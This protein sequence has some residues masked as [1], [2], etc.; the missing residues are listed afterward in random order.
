MP[1]AGGASVASAELSVAGGLKTPLVRVRY[2][3][4]K[5]ATYAVPAS[6]S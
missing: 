2:M 3:T 6:T 5:P 1:L 4:S